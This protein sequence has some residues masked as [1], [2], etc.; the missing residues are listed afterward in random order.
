M[1]TLEELMM[2]AQNKPNKT[3]ALAC[4]ED[5]EVLQAVKEAV[6]LNLCDFVLFGDKNKIKNITK[7]INFNLDNCKIVDINDKESAC[8]EAVKHVSSGQSEV[9]MKGLV[10]T[11]VILKKVLDKEFGLRTE[12]ILSHVMVIQLPKFNRLIFLSDGAM[13]IN[14]NID[15]L[16]QIM[17]N[18]VNLAR[19]LSINRP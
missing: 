6:N 5:H 18:A 1:K 10:D 11:A 9:L 14:P 2:V 3:I 17:I 19:G 16:K 7:E 12:N 15:Q 4:P 13:N 8:F